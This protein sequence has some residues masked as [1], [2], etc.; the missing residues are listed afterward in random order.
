MQKVLNA[1]KVQYWLASSEVV[2]SPSPSQFEPG[3]RVS[4]LIERNAPELL[5]A[6]DTA[7]LPPGS[8]RQQPFMF[9]G[10]P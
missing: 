3:Q 1:L 4:I 2:T 5:T 8:A 10:Q 6:Q 7:N 9:G